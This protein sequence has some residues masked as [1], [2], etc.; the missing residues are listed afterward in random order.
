M[1]SYLHVPERAGE[2]SPRKKVPVDIRKAAE[3]E[4]PDSVRL[5]SA[6]FARSW[7]GVING[8]SRSDAE[9]DDLDAPDHNSNDA[10]EVEGRY[11]RRNGKGKMR[12]Q[13]I[14][15]NLATNSNDI[16]ELAVPRLTTSARARERGVNMISERIAWVGQKVLAD[17]PGTLRRTG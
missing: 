14:M 15:A 10:Q 13:T 12:S 9:F 7:T 8:L 5:K 16:D 11:Q 6:A 17:R 1:P 4:I 3:G 2:S